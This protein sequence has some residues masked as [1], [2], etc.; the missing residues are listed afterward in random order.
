MS[1]ELQ[2]ANRC[3]DVGRTAEALDIEQRL[4]RQLALA[5][6]DFPLVQELQRGKRST[7][8]QPR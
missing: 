2:L 7:M 5:D 4:G 1:L 3:H 6:P 8:S